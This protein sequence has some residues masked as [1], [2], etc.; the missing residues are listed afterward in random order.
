MNM[1]K[2]EVPVCIFFHPIIKQSKLYGKMP[3]Q[4]SSFVS[5]KVE[6]HDEIQ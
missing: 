4:L 5:F 1:I 3:R 2:V 6:L